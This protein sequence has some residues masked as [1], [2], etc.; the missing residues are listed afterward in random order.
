MNR[1]AFYAHLRRRDVPL[2]GTSLSQAQVNGIEGLLDA[3]ATHGDG[4]A[5]LLGYGLATAWWETG[6][7]MVPNREN[8]NYTSAERIRQVFGTRRFPTLA[9]AARFVRKPRELANRVYG[10]RL[11]NRGRDTDD[12]WVY[13]GGGH[14]H[15]TGR[16]N[17]LASSADAGVDL[18][19]T[20]EAILDPQISGR[21]LFRGLLDGRWNA[22][23]KG[24]HHYAMADGIPDLSFNE[25]AEARR[26]VNVQDK[27]REIAA[28]YGH[29]RAALAAAGWQDQP[30]A[31][32]SEAASA[33]PAPA[34]KPDHWF[35]ALVRG[36]VAFFTKR[37][38]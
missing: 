20:P 25:A 22:H 33:P 8:M 35:V 18:T 5:V 7:A 31:P 36:L 24:I 4:T 19:R 28:A 26:T 23:G 9:D 6:R 14:M 2:F 15:L 12:G 21:I 17:Y 16:A 37:N 10:D 38:T 29:F 11:G 27:A 34:A 32:G 30:R 13:R 1:A 3:F